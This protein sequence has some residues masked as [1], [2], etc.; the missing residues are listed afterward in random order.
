SVTVMDVGDAYFSIP[1]DEDFRKYTAF[2]IPSTNN[3]T[4]GV[5]YQYNVLPQGW[6]GSPAIFQSSMT[7]ILEPF[8]AKNPEIVI[9]QYVD[10]LYVGSDLE[11]GQH[12][13]KIKELR[14][15][16]W[17]WGF[18]TPDKK[19]QEEPPFLWMGY[20]LHPDKWTVQPI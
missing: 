11:I 14:E 16:L 7:R 3:E 9:Y 18:Y 20:E 15:Y 12:R 4:P 13:A 2:T 19:H 1:L 17:K 6:K 10:D 8:R 5:R